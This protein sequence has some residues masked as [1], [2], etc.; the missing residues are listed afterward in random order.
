M[1]VTFCGHREINLKEDV[2]LWLYEKV[3][4]LIQAGANTFALGGY[5]E[6]DQMA[7]SVVWELKQKYPKIKS[8]L[9]LPYANKLIDT[10]LYDGTLYP[11]MTGVSKQY[12]II[13]RNHWMVDW[14]DVVVSYV[15][16][17]WGG[18]YKTL[19]Y[20]KSKNKIIEEYHL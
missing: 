17:E 7:A 19:I 10:N 3:E 9:V 20:A 1:I 16:H 12:A 4:K 18:A 11:D 8:I 15:E 14:A 5:G 6:Y 13:Y 2:R